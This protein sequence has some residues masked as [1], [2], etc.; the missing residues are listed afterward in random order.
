MNAGQAKCEG[1]EYVSCEIC[2]TDDTE[3]LFVVEGWR[4]VRCRQC[5]LVYV[6]PRPAPKSLLDVYSQEYFQKSFFDPVADREQ[7][8]NPL[9]WD[10][11]R[12]RLLACGR[13]PGRLLDVGCGTGRFMLQA[14][15]HGWEPVG[16]EYSSQGAQLARQATQAE[17]HVGTVEESPLPP[18]SF[19]AASLLHVLEHVPHPRQT[20]RRLHQ[21]L[22]EKGRLLIE[23]PDF[24]SRHA[25]K[26]GE[27]WFGI[28]PPEH[29]YHYSLPTLGA[30]LRLESFRV[31]KV[32]RTGGLGMLATSEKPAEPAGWARPLYEWRRWLAPTP[33]LRN[34]LRYLYWDVL[35]QHDNLL[36]VAEK[37]T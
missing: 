30:L 8:E 16:V 5:G 34:L 37:V 13:P 20:L 11:Q 24:G 7:I 22:R 21:L 9:S 1:L 28:E 17:V 6:N 27:R 19:D 2:V 33:R 3:L 36:V 12:V 29:L 14:Q 25:R 4:L 31:L 23:V 35:R 32:R 18:G 26:Q 10:R 15:Q